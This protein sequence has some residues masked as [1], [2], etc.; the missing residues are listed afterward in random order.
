MS[1]VQIA[2]LLSAFA[3]LATGLGSIIALAHR[4]P[5]PRFL[6]ASLGLSAGV[7]IESE[8]RIDDIKE[9]V[10]PH[11]TVGEIIREAVFHA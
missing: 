9:I 8:M 3:G 6:G 7:M 1:N 5:G 11:P 4:R 10:F 2:F